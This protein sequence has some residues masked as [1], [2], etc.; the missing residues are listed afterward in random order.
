MMTVHHRDH[1]HAFLG[2]ISTALKPEGE[3]LLL[4]L[5]VCG[6]QCRGGAA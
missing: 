3:A 6:E 2:S 4:A 1:E 5:H